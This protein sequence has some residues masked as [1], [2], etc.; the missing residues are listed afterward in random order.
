MARAEILEKIS[1]VFGRNDVFIKSFRFLQTFNNLSSYFD[2][3]ISASDKEQPVNRKF[4]IVNDRIFYNSEN[5]EHF[6]GVRRR[7]SN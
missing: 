4:S 6:L 5:A 2:A 7:G 1:L 3:R